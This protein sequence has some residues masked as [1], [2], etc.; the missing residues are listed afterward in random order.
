MDTK[1]LKSQRQGD[2]L[3]VDNYLFNKGKINKNGKVR[4][5]CK[6]RK[7]KN[8]KVSVVT[9][10]STNT[11]ESV[12]GEHNHTSISNAEIIFKTAISEVTE[13][14]IQ[15]KKKSAQSICNT[16]INDILKSEDLDPT[17]PAVA[18]AAKIIKGRLSNIKIIKPPAFFNAIIIIIFKFLY[19]F[20]R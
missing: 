9:I 13:S 6:N 5:Y 3:I 11:I 12:E 20:Y 10:N 16:A 2:S 17:D 8:C 1:T 14:A 15:S 19:I 4:W 18:K 7:T